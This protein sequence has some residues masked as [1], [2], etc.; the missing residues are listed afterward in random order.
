MD[1]SMQTWCSKSSGSYTDAEYKDQHIRVHTLTGSAHRVYTMYME[2]LFRNIFAWGWN[3]SS[4]VHTLDLKI[5]NSAVTFNYQLIITEW[6]IS[7]WLVVILDYVKKVKS[8]INV[9]GLVS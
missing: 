2:I 3:P 7:Q 4:H 1:T 5:T 9:F 6:L 8:N